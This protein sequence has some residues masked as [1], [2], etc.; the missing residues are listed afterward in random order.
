MLLYIIG[1][2]LRLID[3]SFNAG[4]FS[5][6]ASRSRELLAAWDKYTTLTDMIGIQCSP[7]QFGDA[8]PEFS[9]LLDGG[10][11]TIHGSWIGILFSMAFRSTSGGLQRHA[12]NF[13]FSLPEEK[14]YFFEE[15]EGFL[16]GEFLSFMLGS[17]HLQQEIGKDDTCQ[18]G[19]NLARFLQK[20]ISQTQNRVSD[21]QL[22][23]QSTVIL[24]KRIAI[25][26]G[27]IGSHT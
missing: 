6:D 23:R 24:T 10:S 11:K 13:I 21:I 22:E 2:S 5:W 3:H 15:A 18:H 19:V 26:C 14:Q 7:N 27:H 12:Y 9:K 1:K 20:F 4:I 16:C 8:L 25:C 17:Q